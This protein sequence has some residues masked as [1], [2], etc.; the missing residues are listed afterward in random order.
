MQYGLLTHKKQRGGEDQNFVGMLVC[1][2]GCCYS[3]QV[4][5]AGGGANKMWLMKNIANWQATYFL[6]YVEFVKK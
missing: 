2:Y 5:L 3:E 1:W 4:S 6:D